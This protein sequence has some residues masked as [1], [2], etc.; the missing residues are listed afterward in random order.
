MDWNPDA[1]RKPGAV[2]SLYFC[3]SGEAPD[4]FKDH[5]T[6]AAVFTGFPLPTPGR[7]KFQYGYVGHY[8][9]THEVR[10]G[11]EEWQACSQL[12]CLNWLHFVEGC[13]TPPPDTATIP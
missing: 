13:I 12:V 2:G 3:W 4:I 10:L 1:P 9:L 8:Q 5:G 7:S 6:E 11:P